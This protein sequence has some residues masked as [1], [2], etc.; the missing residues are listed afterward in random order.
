MEFKEKIITLDGLTKLYS[1][2]SSYGHPSDDSLK[3]K[4]QERMSFVWGEIEALIKLIK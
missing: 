1:S 2:L 3:N 4:Q